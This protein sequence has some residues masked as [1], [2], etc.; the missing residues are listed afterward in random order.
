MEVKLNKLT[1]LI[2]ILG[3]TGALKILE[4]L[5]VAPRRYNELKRTCSSDR[6][7]AQRLK[8]LEECDLVET[9]SQKAEGRFFVHYRVTEKGKNVFSKVK[10]I[11]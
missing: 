6:T 2:E 8:E 4:L 11:K 9:I 1:S 7:L 5:E 3:K 10:E